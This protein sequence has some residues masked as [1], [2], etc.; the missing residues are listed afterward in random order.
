VVVY[1]G[2]SLMCIAMSN[3]MGSVSIVCLSGLRGLDEGTLF[4]SLGGLHG[5][6]LGEGSFTGE[7]GR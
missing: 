7:P 4:P 3:E 5:G 2:I 1:L 6:G